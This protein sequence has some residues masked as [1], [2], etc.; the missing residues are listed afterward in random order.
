MAMTDVTSTEGRTGPAFEWRG[1]GLDVARHFFGVEDIEF[2]IDLMAG[3]GLNMLH[4]HLSDDQGWRIEIPGWPELTERSADNAVDGDPGGYYTLADWSRITDHARR[5]GITVIPEIDLPGHTNAALH[6]IPGLNPD[7]RAT[8]PYTGIEVGFSTLSTEAPQT[9]R[10]IEEILTRMAGIGA[11][12][13]HIGGDE[14][15][16]TPHDQYRDL[17]RRAVDVVHRAGARVIAWQEAADLLKPGDVVQ[18]WDRSIGYQGVLDAAARGVR[19]LQSP[20]NR[21]YL[22][23]KYDPST[24]IGLSWAGT[25]EVREALEW[26]PLD[27]V[28]GLAPSAV[29]GVEACLW[30]ETLRT[31]DDLTYMLLPRLAAFAEVARHGSGIG[32]WEQFRGRLPALARGWS[33]RGLAWHRS[34]GV[35]W[36]D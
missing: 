34:Q 1:L 17:V 25:F 22:D 21:A 6:A 33:E 14:S 13:V 7:G 31:R 8:E 4:L 23:M 28:P 27:T 3:M 29:I 20:G 12:W 35:D 24:P 2:I 5:H 18:V 30:T 16:A 19:V 15:R 9:D 26:D 10:F 36:Q 32:R 11:G